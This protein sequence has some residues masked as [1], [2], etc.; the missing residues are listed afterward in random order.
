[1]KEWLRRMFEGALPAAV[2]GGALA[3]LGW[4]LYQDHRQL[5][6]L[7][8]QVSSLFGSIRVG[9]GGVLQLAQQPPPVPQDTPQAPAPLPTK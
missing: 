5:H 3:L 7:T 4:H 1:V 2:L 9:P 8:T 6:D